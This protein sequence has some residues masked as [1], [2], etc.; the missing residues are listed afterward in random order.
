MKPWLAKILGLTIMILPANYALATV[1]PE[2][3]TIAEVAESVVVETA[4]T[5]T[6]TQYEYDSNGNVIKNLQYKNGDVSGYTDFE[7]GLENNLISISSYLDGQLV[8]KE[9]YE[10]QDGKF[11]EAK[12]YDNGQDLSMILDYTYT[13]NNNIETVS[14]YDGTGNLESYTVYEYNEIGTVSKH[15]VYDNEDK[16]QSYVAYKYDTKGNLIEENTSTIVDGV[17]YENMASKIYAYDENDNRIR[18]DVYV[19][20]NNNNNLVVYNT[21]EYDAA[22]NLIQESMYTST[23]VVTWYMIYEYDTDGRLVKTMLHDGD[24]TI[25]E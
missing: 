2:T 23:G 18:R 16:L 15:S 1:E 14:T 24:G 5:G 4:D 9:E 20:D 21:Y 8:Y 19:K 12:Y 10:Y 13:D 22:N 7:Y 17:A 6:Y 3:A 11:V 25:I